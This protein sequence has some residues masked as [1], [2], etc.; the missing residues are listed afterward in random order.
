[1]LTSEE[2]LCSI[3]LSITFVGIEIQKVFQNKQDKVP[4]GNMK[5]DMVHVRN[6]EPHM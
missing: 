2:G 5:Q 4:Q 6:G 3:T 1:V